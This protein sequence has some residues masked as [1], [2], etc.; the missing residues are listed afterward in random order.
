M[1]TSKRRNLALLN[2]VAGLAIIVLAV[3]L[4]GLRTASGALDGISIITV[5]A[6]LV[7]VLT[8]VS[9]MFRNRRTGSTRAGHRPQAAS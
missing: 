4:F 2:I 6:G 8:G 9:N 3:L 5:V 7:L 1:D